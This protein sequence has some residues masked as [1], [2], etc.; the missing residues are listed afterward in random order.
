MRTTPSVLTLTLALAAGG[1]VR[2]ATPAH[3]TLFMKDAAAAGM[4]EVD[5][6]KLAADKATRADVKSFAQMLVDDHSKANDE[7]KGLAGQKNVTL[8]AGPKPMQKA[9]HDRLAKLSGS[10]FDTAYVNQM[11][12]DHRQ[13]VSLFDRESRYGKDADAKAW[14]AKT[15]PTLKAHLAKAQELAAAGKP[16]AAAA[17]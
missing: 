10:A 4:A 9:A 15:L 2:A 3:D 1:A 5:T 17:K 14:A 16:A 6:G 11:V 13:A 12:R 8:P 7:L